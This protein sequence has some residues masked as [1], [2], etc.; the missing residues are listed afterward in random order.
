MRR[1]HLLKVV[2]AENYAV[3]GHMLLKEYMADHDAT[4]QR[5]GEKFAQ[6]QSKFG[7][8]D[9]FAVAKLAVARVAW[10]VAKELGLVTWKWKPVEK[11][12]IKAITT[13]H[14]ASAAAPSADG[15]GIFAAF[16]S[17]I[18]EQ[19]VTVRNEAG[20]TDGRYGQH[21]IRGE[22]LGRWETE[23]NRIWIRRSAVR[24]HC[25][26]SRVPAN[27]IE[28][29]LKSIGALIDDNDHKNLGRGFRP[30]SRQRCLLVDA[31]KI[32]LLVEAANS[33]EGDEDVD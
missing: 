18:S 26:D 11:V 13:Q 3:P 8:R 31:A 6:Y 29:H 21:S 15:E 1:R 2:L 33:T 19:I 7:M 14:E 23:N 10:E 12:I 24:K 27:S 25:A 5:V 20:L 22:L 16:L 28:E 4:R 17:S 30:E 32:G 9:R